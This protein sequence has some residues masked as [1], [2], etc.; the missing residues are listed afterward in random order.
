MPHRRHL[1]GKFPDERQEVFVHDQHHVF[2]M[3]DRIQ[4][5]GGRQ[6]PVD[7]MKHVP[8]HG[9]RKITLQIPVAVIIHN[10]YRF[11][12]IQT[13]SQK[14]IR[15]AS[16]TF[17]KTVI[18]VTNQILVDNLPLR[19]QHQGIV[20]QAFYQQREFAAGRDRRQFLYFHVTNR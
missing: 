18:I 14:D 2:R 1:A 15:K 6:P 5:L 20:Q 19:L 13:Q 3:I 11:T 7:R 8:R 9:D 4:D 16:D 12:A 17:I 10:S